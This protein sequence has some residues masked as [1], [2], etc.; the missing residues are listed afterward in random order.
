MIRVVMPIAVTY[1]EAIKALVKW[2]APAELVN[3]TGDDYAY[4]DLFLRLWREGKPFI[5]VEHDIVIRPD[6][7]SDLANCG[8]PWCAYTYHEEIGEPVTGM[9]CTKFEPRGRALHT[10]DLFHDTIWQNVDTTVAGLLTEL[11]WK[12]HEH[13]PWLRHLNPRVAAMQESRNPE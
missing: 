11:G 4:W 2:V 1:P 5:I 8:A 7:V 12:V 10:E 13:G 9:G 6:T 3:V